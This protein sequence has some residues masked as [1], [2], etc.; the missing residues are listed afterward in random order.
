VRSVGTN[1]VHSTSEALQHS[2]LTFQVFTDDKRRFLRYVTSMSHVI[3]ER[4]GVP[5]GI[6]D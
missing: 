2:S 6:A 3:K 4:M 1:L 5:D